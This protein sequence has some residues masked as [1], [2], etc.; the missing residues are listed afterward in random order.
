M[1]S[2]WYSDDYKYQM[3]LLWY[4]SGRPGAKKLRQRIPDN[5]GENKPMDTTLQIWI[6]GEKFQSQAEELDKQVS[7]ELESRLVKEKVEMLSRH[8]DLGLRM[9]DMAM[10]YLNENESSLS[11]NAAVRLLIEGIRV[12]RDSK[13]I[14]QA[15][16]K[17]MN[18]ADDDLVGEIKDILKQSQV[19]ILED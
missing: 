1:T 11:A 17:M 12:E 13:G 10:N 6:H 8:A 9:Q 5:W 19:E 16:E 14:P 2:D 7:F 4:N 15:I 3:F 18:L